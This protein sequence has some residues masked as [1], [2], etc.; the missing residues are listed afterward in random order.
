[1]PLPDRP[2]KLSRGARPGYVRPIFG[3]IF[4]LGL[5]MFLLV[6]QLPDLQRDWRINRNP[7]AVEDSQ[8]QNGQCTTRQ[9]I[10]TDCEATLVYTV[11][12]TNYETDVAVMFID[13]HSGD[14]TVDVVQSGDD[15]ALAT[16]SIGLENHGNGSRS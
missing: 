1:M 2:L 12:G 8:V 15:P 7:V 14:Y 11:D 9:V 16:I 13:L 5:S 3:G 10:F 6:W 4:T